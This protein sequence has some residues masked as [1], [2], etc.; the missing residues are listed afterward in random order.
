M[1][2]LR[3]FLLVLA[4][5]LLASCG[6]KGN[7]TVKKVDSL[8][9]ERRYMEASQELST[10]L[11][12]DPKNE[13]LI[14]AQIRLFLR[15]EEPVYAMAAFKK[16]SETK[17]NSPVLE[18]ALKEDD[19]A[20]RVTAV[21]TL[22]ILKDEKSLE[23]L[24][25]AA[26]DKDAKVRLATIS[27]LGSIG[28]AKA[29]PVLIQA[30]KDESWSIR[31]EAARSLG[32]LGDG[33]AAAEL[34]PLL[35]DEDSYV[36][37]QTRKAL[38]LLA[39]SENIDVFRKGITSPN[40]SVKLTS[41]LA[42]LSIHDHSAIPILLEELPKISPREQR[43]MMKE[44]VVLNDPVAIPAIRGRMEA[45]DD[46]V[47][48]EAVLS[49]ARLGDQESKASISKLASDANQPA[50]VRIA[51]RQALEILKA[52]KDEPISR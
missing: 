49:L 30:L 38:L 42:L 45:E 17:P 27:A 22:G 10:A 52:K 33:K 19:T 15:K 1:H 7:E 47:R 16:L 11:S 46:G 26:K 2:L 4:I 32:I 24:N 51:S 41:A 28:N 36:V 23:A 37:E 9:E 31:A 48:A 18:N 12:M 44:L 3:L 14:E 20:M 13:A 25:K 35:Q 40:S 6:P 8:L 29:I 50:A 21:K 34:F 43:N 5:T 39:K